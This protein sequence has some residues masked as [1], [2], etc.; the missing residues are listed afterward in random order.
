MKASVYI[1]TSMDGFIAREDGALD[2][3]TGSDGFASGEGQHDGEQQDSEQTE[4]ENA[5]EDEDYGYQ[6]FMDSVDV[7]IIGRGTYETVLSFGGEWPYGDKRVVV[8]SNSLTQL[9]DHLPPAVELRASTPTEVVRELEATGAT[10][11]YVD[12]GKTIQSFL[13]AGLIQE[14]TIT[15]IPVLIGS[16]IP[17]FGPLEKDVHLEHIETR[18]F[19]NGFVQSKYA[20]RT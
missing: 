20:V 19:D 8:L 17:L 12:G 11:A 14:M 15:R 6:A 18:A 1:A 13:N 3:L 10:H 16:G 5:G 2:W 7:L 4:S 9:P